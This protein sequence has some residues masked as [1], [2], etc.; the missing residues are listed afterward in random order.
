M[1]EDINIK[2]TAALARQPELR[3]KLLHLLR[4]HSS[5]DEAALGIQASLA[6]RG[7]EQRTFR[8]TVQLACERDAAAYSQ[9]GPRCRCNSS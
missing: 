5:S 8:D 3:E 6:Q 1:G 4:D 2:L 7:P 9:A